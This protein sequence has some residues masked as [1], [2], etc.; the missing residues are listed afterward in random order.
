M[1][2]TQAGAV[3]RYAD[4]LADLR[5]IPLAACAL[6]HRLIFK[7]RPRD[8]RIACVGYAELAGS[9]RCKDTIIEYV[10]ALEAVHLIVRER[11]SALVDGR[12]RRMPNRYHFRTVEE[13]LAASLAA[14]D[15]PKQPEIVHCTVSLPPC[16]LTF[17][18][19]FGVVEKDSS[20]TVPAVRGSGSSS[21]W[22]SGIRRQ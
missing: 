10:R 20:L 14:G 12:W 18:T 2:P 17:S 9:G 22:R 21:P 5:A 8:G 11:W 6:L 3:M 7:Y 15:E 1:S 16:K 4:E 19:S 13:A